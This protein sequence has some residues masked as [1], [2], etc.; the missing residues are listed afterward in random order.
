MKVLLSAVFS[1][2]IVGRLHQQ[3]SPPPPAKTTVVV[4]QGSG[5]DHGVPERQPA[6]LRL[7]PGRQP[8]GADPTD[9]PA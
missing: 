5:H 7:T 9:C 3:Q 4:P 2:G 8:C 1:S 6:A